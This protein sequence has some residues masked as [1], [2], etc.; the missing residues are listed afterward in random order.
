MRTPPKS[1]DCFA[2]YDPVTGRIYASTAQRAEDVAR[3]EGCIAI[4]VTIVARRAA[5]EPAMLARL[6]AFAVAV[7]ELPYQ[8]LLIFFTL[9]AST[10]TFRE[11]DG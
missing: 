7:L 4:P 2:P 1:E 10:V 8:L 6:G 3:L 5:P 11:N 9:V